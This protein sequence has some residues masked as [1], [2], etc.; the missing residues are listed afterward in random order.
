VAACFLAVMLPTSG[1]TTH[2]VGDSKLNDISTNLVQLDNGLCCGLKV[3]VASAQEWDERN[4]A[5]RHAVRCRSSSQSSSKRKL[6]FSA[7]QARPKSK[8]WC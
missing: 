7:S 6:S 2:R 8:V 1:L 4:P 3:W 5:G